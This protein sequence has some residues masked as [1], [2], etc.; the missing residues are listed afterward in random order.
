MI[1]HLSRFPPKNRRLFEFRRKH[2]TA[3]SVARIDGV[4]HTVGEDIGQSIS[5]D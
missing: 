3:V 5:I 4:L 2:T 1:H